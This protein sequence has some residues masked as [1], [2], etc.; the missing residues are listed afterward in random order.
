MER[1]QLR[2]QR[3]TSHMRDPV[4][5][6]GSTCRSIPAWGHPRVTAAELAHDEPGP[7]SEPESKGALF[8][9]AS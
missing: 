3:G 9:R 4:T 2:L 8:N 5:I 7:G 1:L 6:M